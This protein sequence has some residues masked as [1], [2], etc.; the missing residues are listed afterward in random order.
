MG[1]RPGHAFISYASE[2][3]DDVDRLH[4]ILVAAGISVWRDTASLWP[5]QDW[6]VK[7]REAITE[8][9]L[10]FIACFSSRSITKPRSYQRA[11]IALAI[12]EL[13]LREPNDPWIFPV[14]FDDCVI[15]SREIGGGL[16]LASIHQTD[17]FGAGR[18]MAA[19][20]LV[21]SIVRRFEQDYPIISP[22]SKPTDIREG[23][24]MIGGSFPR[25]SQVT[26][27][28][29]LGVHPATPMSSG[30]GQAFQLLVPSYVFRNVDTKL[31]R[32]L[33]PPR[34][35][36]PGNGFV[37]L[38]GDATS[39]KSRTAYEAIR[40]TLP[41]Y[42]LIA[43]GKREAL[44]SALAAAAGFD[45]CVLWLND[46]E[47]FFG[48]G[49][50]TPDNVG[51]LL[52]DSG[53]RCVIVAT[54]RAA[55]EARYTSDAEGPEA[56]RQAY[57]DS[58]EVLARA[59][60]FYLDRMFA[61]EEQERARAMSQDPRVV[62]AVRFADRYGIAEFLAAAP[63][64]LSAWQDGWTT[65][66]DSSTLANP[67]GAA[68][69]E[70]AV[71][72]RRAGWASPIPREL[73][74]RVRKRYLNR[75]GGAGLRPEDADAAWE[76]ACRPRQATTA[77]LQ[78]EDDERVQVFD[79]LVDEVRGPGGEKLPVPD[80]VVQAAVGFAGPAE[81]DALAA[82]AFTEG[83][84]VLAEEAYRHAYGL[85]AGDPD[86]LATLGTR[87]KL[88]LVLKALGRLQEA[89]AEHQAV[90]DILRRVLGPDHPRTL[91]NRN[92]RARVLRI[93]GLLHE[94]EAEHRAVRDALLRTSGPEHADTLAASSDLAR[95][96]QALGRL[97]QAA[98]EHKA[99]LGIRMRLLG[100]EH[101]STLAS[102]GSLASVLHDLGR[103]TEAEA[104]HRK[105][106]ASR[107]KLLGPDHPRTLT[108]RGDL[109]RV[110]HDLG[111]LS[112]AEAEQRTVYA[113]R[114]DVLGPQHH[115]TLASRGTLATILRDLGRLQE[116]ETEFR[117]VLASRTS[118]LGPDH[119][120]TLTSRA[121]L[122][123]LLQDRG[124]LD[125]A[126]AEHRAV[127]HLR[128]QVLGADHPHTLS[129]RYELARTLEELGNLAEAEAEHR[130]TLELRT[131]N[132]GPE[133]PSTRAS[134]ESLAA[135]QER[136]RMEDSH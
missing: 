122:A 42:T 36:S 136:I 10:V 8:N 119:P 129:S 56:G 83:R 4:A 49:A 113:S 116:A 97:E 6:E 131:R 132:L 22:R 70:A 24:L 89:E 107:I 16:T 23:C 92:D 17:L 103:L 121:D 18:D 3:A 13:R 102:R 28:L 135:V 95:V 81:A 1:T 93:L 101:P 2:D 5:G 79:Y 120:R 71:D 96:L 20:R 85:R 29:R 104:E 63:Q 37:L 30:H 118:E 82:T 98:A 87:N 47:R 55:E 65:K 59:H 124:Q 134:Q 76:W 126:A 130:F 106:L 72:V 90:G 45:Q 44:P 53:R 34:I 109:A 114:K 100:P 60:R 77:L 35:G 73:L 27:P 112:D 48:A 69:V 117:A 52:D 128:E 80:E 111:R 105:V 86:D 12:E 84:Y 9:A 38:V 91:I 54:M 99:V 21:A 66:K 61:R 31:R 110:L 7:I 43:P 58:R 25:V 133:H 33:K 125:E 32:S 40:A 15:P 46:L 62:G 108:S 74:W 68:L 57:G 14:R 50:L 51:D 94:A 64:L 19:D 26:N 75:R 41:G 67:L 88:A 115:R 39:G 11:E 123:E 78:P 127:L